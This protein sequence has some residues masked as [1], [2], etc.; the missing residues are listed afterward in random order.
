MLFQV[1][2]LR[3]V[4]EAREAVYFPP[5][6]AANVLR[7]ALGTILDSA[8]FSPKL[9][10]GPSGLSDPPRP[11]VL[12]AAPLD[13][14]RIAAGKTFEFGMNVFH[15]VPVAAY[16]N[17]VREL[18]TRGLGPGRSRVSLVRFDEIPVAIDLSLPR[19]GT[20]DVRVSFVTPTELK[21]VDGLVE[22]PDF[23]VLLA[24]IRD[25]VS[26][27]RALYGDGAVEMDYRAFGERARL[28][29][30][31]KCHVKP[32]HRERT[33]SRTGQT[34]SIGGFTGDAEYQGELAEFTPFLDAAVYAG[35]GRQTVWGKGEIAW[36]PLESR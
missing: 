26:T 29:K 36:Q 25:R 15:A 9:K 27:L 32:V 11:F 34:H 22:R 12:R 17:A 4:M 1:R 13:G 18:E 21:G 3:F 2:C 8:I 31:T 16:G 20:R 7:G 5:G 14:A 35:V 19:E 10:D 6:K 30:M 33:S 24:R 28:V 23:G